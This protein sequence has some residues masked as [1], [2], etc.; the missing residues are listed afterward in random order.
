[1]TGAPASATALDFELGEVRARAMRNNW[2]TLFLLWAIFCAF[3]LA[4]VYL[5]I[6]GF[7]KGILLGSV[8]SVDGAALVFAVSLMGFVSS[9]ALMSALTALPGAS[10]LRM[11]SVGVELWNREILLDSWHWDSLKDCF[12]LI[13]C[14]QRPNAASEDL[15]VYIIRGG[16]FWSRNSALTKEAFDA[17]LR[18]AEQFGAQ[19]DRHP[20]SPRSFSYPVTVYQIAGSRPY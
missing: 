20:G 6:I 1:M 2:V 8:A 14:S 15:P 9:Y 3:A 18:A 11:S 16:K 4:G 17:I 13:D 7:K 5:V 19:V 10:L 12:S